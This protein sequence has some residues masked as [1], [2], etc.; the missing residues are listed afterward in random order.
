MTTNTAVKPFLRQAFGVVVVGVCLA[1]AYLL[2]PS[3]GK[4][5]EIAMIALRVTFVIYAIISLLLLFRLRK[6][7][8]IRA[9]GDPSFAG[10]MLREGPSRTLWGIYRR[11]AFP[12]IR[13]SL[14]YLLWSL[15][16][17][18][19]IVAL[20]ATGRVHDAEADLLL[21]LRM[22]PNPDSTGAT[23][24][25]MLEAGDNN[26]TNYLRDLLQITRDMKKCGARV[27][28]ARVP[29]MIGHRE[30]HKQLIDSIA[31]FNI[32]ILFS[33][34]GQAGHFVYPFYIPEREKTFPPATFFVE[35]VI[36]GGI[37]PVGLI[38]WTP[39]DSMHTPPPVDAIVATTARFIG[40]ADTACA[41]LSKRELL[42]YGSISL[43]LNSQGKAAVF[44][45]KAPRRF[46]F[47][48][49][50]A[51]RGLDLDT[52][53]YIVYPMSASDSIP[54]ISDSF[55]GNYAHEVQGRIVFV[56]WIPQMHYEWGMFPLAL[57]VEALL[58][59]EVL[60]EFDRASIYAAGLVILLSALICTR[61]RPG[62][63]AGLILSFGVVGMGCSML[64]LA[65]QHILL[66]AA[67]P[68][69]AAFLSGVI[70]PLVR[71][72]HEHP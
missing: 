18:G 15:L 17:M 33:G 4:Y 8:R 42:R 55:P 32:A 65:Q 27:V 3:S 72:S 21:A 66:H 44:L 14:L 5:S 22:N 71:L 62:V 24:I 36:D 2:L 49:V 1:C 58:Q 7:L 37:P 61:F 25:I 43:P 60:T 9:K 26:P 13:L 20:F 69:A 67:Y 68:V 30:I 64:L 52:L 46:G 54:S 53:K 59:N 51:V 16:I 12:D 56:E 35:P 50:V 31:S 40:M 63:A 29:T 34:Y 57:V 39:C 47:L 70:F 11:Q 19:F 10:S 6:E 23:K 45:R 38:R 48:S 28:V 41:I